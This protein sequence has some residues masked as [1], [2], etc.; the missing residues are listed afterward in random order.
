M[1]KEHKEKEK[2][3][4]HKEETPKTK[5]PD[6][7]TIFIIVG[8]ALVAIVIFQSL[9]L[10][11]VIGG[12]G[13]TDINKLIREITPTG[14]PDYGSATGVS[15]DRIESSLPIMAGW[16]SSI[17]LD[18]ADLDRYIKVATSENT[19]CEYCCGIGNRG[20]GTSEGQIACGC[21]HNVAFSGLTKYLIKNSDYSNEDIIKEIVNWKILFFP[22]DAVVDE[23]QA[24]GINPE[25]A[26]LPAMVGGC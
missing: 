7:K 18:G 21:S 5:K 8:V 22:Q 25:A 17:S 15:Y 12:K 23:L 19:A 13:T 3:E 4:H 24:R 6:Y 1:E 2:E 10:T 14:T 11:G 26:G 20:F 16:H 9:L